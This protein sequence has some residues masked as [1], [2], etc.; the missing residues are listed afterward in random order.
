MTTTITVEIRDEIPGYDPTTSRTT[1]QFVNRDPNFADALIPFINALRGHGH[2]ITH[3]DEDKLRTFVKE[4]LD[5]L[6]T[7]TTPKVYE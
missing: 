4:N 2:E 1:Q 3:D 7:D 5:W 6:E